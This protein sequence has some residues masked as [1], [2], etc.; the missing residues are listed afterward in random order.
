MILAQ[1]HQLAVRHRDV[2]LA[3]MK[4]L[5]LW[6]NA[7]E[8]VLSPL[9]RTTFLGVVWDSTLMQARLSPARIE[10]ILSAVKS[11]RLGQ[12]LT[13]F[14]MI[15]V[16]RNKPWNVEETVVPVPGSHAGSFVSSQNANNRCL[17]HELGSVPRGTLESRSVEGPAFSWHINRLEMLAVF[18]ALKNFLADLRGHHVLVPEVVELI[19]R[20]FGQ[21]QMDLLASRETSY[22]P[23]WFS[24]THPAPL[25]QEVRVQTWPML[26]LYAFPPIALLPGV[27]E[28]VRR[29]RVLLLLI[30]PQW[31]GR[32]WFPD[33][34]SLLDGPPLELPIR[35]DLL[36]QAG[37][38]IFHP[39]PEL[40]KLW[41]WPLRGPSSYTQ[42][43]QP[44]LLRPF[45]TQ[46]LPPRGNFM[47]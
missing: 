9:Q 24:L 30:A 17:S 20:E 35:R 39:H 4:E 3:H 2:M 43:S 12:S 15:K 5:G 38:S 44:R 36:S 31:S 10:S 11:L 8:S 45:F 47:P 29:D 7:K 41:A 23:L 13:P 28:G 18:L 22:C 6:L 40:W 21:A 33:L 19:W 42:V 16:T 32:V 46:E 27:L 14:R 34:I 1:S 37:D 26:R 25:G